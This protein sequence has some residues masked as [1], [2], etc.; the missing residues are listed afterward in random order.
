[1]NIF[2]MPD[3]EYDRPQGRRQYLSIAKHQRVARNRHSK[4][5]DFPTE[6]SVFD[7]ADNGTLNQTQGIAWLDDN[8]NLWGFLSDFSDVG[9]NGEQFGFFDN[10]NNVV[11]RW[12][13]FP[14]IPFSN[15][16]YSISDN[17][18]NR[19]VNEGVFDEDDIPTLL[20]K[21]KIR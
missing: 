15:P 18:L 21:R 6:R 4:W 16:R 8:G 10:P 5:I 1:M 17:L 2:L 11:H 7:N 9:L 12:H 19:W 14:I 20:K 3:R 13:G